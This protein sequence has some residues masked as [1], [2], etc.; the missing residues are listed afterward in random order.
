MSIDLNTLTPDQVATLPA[1][2]RKRVIL[3]CSALIQGAASADEEAPI[4]DKPEYYLTLQEVAERLRWSVDRV[5]HY[6]FPKSVRIGRGQYSGLGL[7]AWERN[8]RMK[9]TR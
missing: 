6:P 7:D 1:A 4:A 8:R 5:K 9:G 2:E 3:R